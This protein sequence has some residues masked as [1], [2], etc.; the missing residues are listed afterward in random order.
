MIITINRI[1]ALHDG[2]NWNYSNV[3]ELA[4]FEDNTN[5]SRRALEYLDA[6]QIASG[7][8]VLADITPGMCGCYLEAAAQ[9]VRNGLVAAEDISS[10]YP[11][12]ELQ[13]VKDE[14]MPF[15]TIYFE[16]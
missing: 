7:L 13:S 3:K 9:D 10:D 16:E 15:L 5:Y 4:H 12:Y 11:V 8:H 1:D 2:E 14:Y 6:G